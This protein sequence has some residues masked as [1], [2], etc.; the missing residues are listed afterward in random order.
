MYLQP[1]ARPAGAGWSG[2]ASAA[3]SGLSPSSRSAWAC[4]TGNWAELQ[5]TRQIRARP[6]EAY[7]CCWHDVG[8]SAT[9]CWS[10]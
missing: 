4:S 2:M 9:L 5:G 6:L 7:A 1:A 3:L 10:K 8:T